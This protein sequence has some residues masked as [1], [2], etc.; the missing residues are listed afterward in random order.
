M[1]RTGR[2]GALSAAALPEIRGAPGRCGRSGR[3]DYGVSER[4]QGLDAH[5]LG[6]RLHRPHCLGC[7][8]R[9]LRRVGTYA[10]FTV[11]YAVGTEPPQDGY[12]KGWPSNV[13]IAVCKQPQPNKRNGRAHVP[14]GT[15]QGIRSADAK[16]QRLSTRRSRWNGGY[17]GAPVAGLKTRPSRHIACITTASLRA[18][19]TAARLKPTFSFSFRPQLRSALSERTRVSITVAAS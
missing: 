10:G 14:A 13:H 12:S 7:G 6:E 19:A 17:A 15:S 11:V 3:A 5:P 1:A 4:R 2:G 16:P 8:S 18:R 9:R